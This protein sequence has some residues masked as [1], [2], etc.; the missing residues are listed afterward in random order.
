[1]SQKVEFLKG[2]ILVEQGS[3]SVL[4]DEKEKITITVLENG[5]PNSVYA[6]AKYIYDLLSARV[7]K[8]S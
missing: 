8:Q 1:M 5:K 4:F 6:S 7:A 3:V 2:R